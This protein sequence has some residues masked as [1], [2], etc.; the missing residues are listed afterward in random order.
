MS[1]LIV[2]DLHLT[3]KFDDNKFKFLTDLFDKFDQ[4]IINGDFWDGYVTDVKTFINSGWAD[5]LDILNSK[6]VFY[7]LGNHDDLIFGSRKV[8]KAIKSDYG[9]QLNITTKLHKLHIEHGHRIYPFFPDLLIHPFW[10]NFPIYKQFNSHASPRI[11]QFLVKIFPDHK[12]TR[13]KNKHM[14]KV[15]H[16]FKND[17]EIL[18]SGH[19]HAPEL[20]LNDSYINS[21]FI[22]HGL[23]YYIS[24]IDDK[25][26]LV[27]KKF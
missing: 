11:E 27:N 8:A 26:S 5:L 24:I 19:T 21:G 10:Y 18:I 12:F 17:S 20:S 1:T 4:I 23:A 7:I 3:N 13:P 25:I 2:S 14:K 9:Y 16:N 22:N 6:D 15:M